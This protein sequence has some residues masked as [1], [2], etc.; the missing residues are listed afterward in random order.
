[1]QG[2]CDSLAFSY[3]DSVF[4]LYE[5]PVL[6]NDSSQMTAD[7]IFIRT[8]N[9]KPYG[10]DLENNAFII[11]RSSEGLFNQ[12]KGQ[13]IN[14][15]FADD[16]L[17]TMH[18]TGNGESVYYGKDDDQALVGMNS[19]VCSRMLILFAAEQVSSI[20]FIGAPE[21]SFIPIQQVNPADHLLAGFVWRNDER[22]KSKS[23]LQLRY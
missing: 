3:S 8:V 21:A 10:I 5:D 15:E 11:S 22:P 9:S 1:M 20:T 14:G 16:E 4:R 7:S 12:V 23:D 19:A 13:R 18:V 6:W 17:R 2:S